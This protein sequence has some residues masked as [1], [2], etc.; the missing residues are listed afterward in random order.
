MFFSI[1]APAHS[2]W[3]W[4]QDRGH[5]FSIAAGSRSDQ[6]ILTEQ[7]MTVAECIAVLE[8]YAPLDLAEDWDNVG[9]LLGQR[10]APLEKVM[11]C[12][13]LSTD[14]AHEA[15][16]GGADLIV[17][18]HPILFQPTQ[19]LTD[20][21]DEGSVILSLAASG[22]AVYSPHT[23]F[24]SAAEGIN[25]Q[26]AEGLKLS[27]VAPL[28]P[29]D[30]ADPSRLGSG[31]FGQLGSECT[32]E[33]FMDQV[34]QLLGVQIIG[35]VGESAASVRTV[36]IACGSAAEFLK[37]AE[38]CGCDVLLTGE[39]RFHACLEARARRV[40]LVLPG[41][42]ATERH[43]VE[44]LAQMLGRTL[45]GVECWASRVEEDPLQWSVK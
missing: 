22:V 14:V 4:S 31:R 7:T 32:L 43:A 45:P 1:H 20:E 34:R 19:R 41:H 18:H 3:K 28:R 38:H 25:Q 37:E 27:G 30:D 33:G 24:D 23:A 17:T 16:E 2:P 10:E 9:L 36:G 5:D 15:I 26:L 35:F 12:L 6:T 40:A 44:S 8:K 42:Y 21:T 39:A 29:R 13:T 11:T